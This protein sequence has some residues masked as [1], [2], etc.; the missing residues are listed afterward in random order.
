[1]NIPHVEL[2]NENTLDIIAVIIVMS[3]FN[4]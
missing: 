2:G 1:M 3:K 4:N